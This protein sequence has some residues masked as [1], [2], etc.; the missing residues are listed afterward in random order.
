M[1]TIATVC[2]LGRSPLAPGTLGSLAGLGVIWLLRDSTWLQAAG[3]GVAIGL[4]L[5]SAGPTARA[6][7]QEDPRAVVIDELAGI[8][9][10]LAWLPAQGWIYAAGF[11][12]FR[13]LDIAKPFPIRHLQRLPGSLGIVLDDLV[14]GLAAN[15]ALRA[16]LFLL[17]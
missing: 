12:L 2:G 11:A 8:M 5:W 6:M 14:A 13:V 7:G 9:V 16:A 10:A 1:R 4:A 17:R 15:L 3:C